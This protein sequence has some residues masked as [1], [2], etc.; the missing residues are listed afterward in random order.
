[1]S[2]VACLGG[3]AIGCVATSNWIEQIYMCQVR[4]DVKSMR[5]EEF[6][7]ADRRVYNPTISVVVRFQGGRRP[8]YDVMNLPCHS[9]MRLS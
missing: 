5:S 8:V 2:L 6:K 7:Q 3:Q 4:C 1:M 9:I